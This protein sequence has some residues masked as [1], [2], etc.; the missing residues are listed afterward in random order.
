MNKT[1]LAAA[2]PAI[3]LSV[4]A[5]ADNV[6]KYTIKRCDTL[7]QIA[8]A[9]DTT[10][11]TLWQLNPYI[12][13]VNKIYWGRTLVGVN[14][15]DLD[16]QLCRTEPT[17]TA[18]SEDDG[19]NWWDG[20][21]YVAGKLGAGAMINSSTEKYEQYAIDKV[22]LLFE[23]DKIDTINMGFDGKY[24]FALGYD[25]GEIRVEWEYRASM[26]EQIAKHDF[27]VV[28]EKGNPYD[29]TSEMI[30][31]SFS[32]SQLNLYWNVWS[33]D[34]KT[35]VFV[36]GG[37]G[38]L[39][40][41]DVVK[42]NVPGITSIGIN[43]DSGLESSDLFAVLG[44]GVEYAYNEDITFDFGINYQVSFGSNGLYAMSNSKDFTTEVQNHISLVDAMFGIR[45][46][47]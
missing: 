34:E 17:E 21:F 41:K 22:T 4:N 40:Y 30:Y 33:P 23:S 1:I 32:S 10:V 44:A 16:L 5:N 26:S 18:S 13:D 11:S 46:T 42:V 6:E 2:L 24:G 31:K 3:I 29:A 47:F 14:P 20:S 8:Q 19:R 25:F 45:Y 28:D 9:T 12:K 27:K 38:A 36:N 37:L 15:T 43:Y 39:S 35:N 7:S